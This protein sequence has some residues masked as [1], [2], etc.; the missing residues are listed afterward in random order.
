MVIYNSKN[1]I[2]KVLPGVI[3]NITTFKQNNYVIWY[4]YRMIFW[5]FAIRKEQDINSKKE[6]KAKRKSLLTDSNEVLD[7]EGFI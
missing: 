4:H 5:W 7:Q 3:N 2:K 1:L 6:M